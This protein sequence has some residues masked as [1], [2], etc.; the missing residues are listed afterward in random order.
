M[1]T[2]GKYEAFKM[3][4]NSHTE[5]GET[6]GAEEAFQYFET[7]EANGEVLLIDGDLL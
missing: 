6:F 2:M 1:K 4:A 7:L 5:E 3:V